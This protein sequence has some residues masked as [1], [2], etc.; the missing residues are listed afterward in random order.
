MHE[1]SERAFA[2]IHAELQARVE[3]AEIPSFED[4]QE[5]TAFCQ[6]F[7]GSG[8]IIDWYE[9]RRDEQGRLFCDR[10]DPQVDL[11]EDG[12]IARSESF[13]VGVILGDV[14]DVLMEEKRFLDAV[15]LNDD[16]RMHAKRLLSRYEQVLPS[17]DLMAKEDRS[18]IENHFRGELIQ[19]MARLYG[20]LLFAERAEEADAVAA[21]LLGAIDTPEAR[22]KLVS[23]GMSM[24]E[25]IDPSWERW[26]GEAE[27]AGGDVEQLRGKLNRLKDLK[28][29]G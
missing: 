2:A 9:K 19:D 17:L 22:L 1:P 16:G 13:L 20:A 23:Q 15:R 21:S 28:E 3:A 5:W 11:S 26:L 10:A 7:D 24:T 29:D 14:F 8:P 4:W 12:R 27:R 25:R 18:G 6:Y